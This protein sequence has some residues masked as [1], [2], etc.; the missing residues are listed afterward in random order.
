MV[1]NGYNLVLYDNRK[2]YKL[3]KSTLEKQSKQMKQ[4]WQ[5]KNYQLKQK[6]EAKQRWQNASEEQR[7]KW[8]NNLRPNKEGLGRSK[9]TLCVETGIVY[10]SCAEAERQTGIKGIHKA[11]NGTRKTAGK[12][13][14]RFIE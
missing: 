13:H 12:M 8:L 2:H 4:R 3:A 5:D 9:K 7:K 10:K 11:A 1:P 14:W 6:I